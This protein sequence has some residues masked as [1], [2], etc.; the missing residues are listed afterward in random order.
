MSSRQL[1]EHCS[2]EVR[3][4][5]SG[6]E[7]LINLTAEPPRVW[8]WKRWVQLQRLTLPC[9]HQIYHI[10]N[11]ETRLFRPGDTKSE[12][13]LAPWRGVHALLSSACA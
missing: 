12:A 6:D 10:M 4:T 5:V 1:I 13:A 9:H 2:F 11:R 7:V 8:H 3:T